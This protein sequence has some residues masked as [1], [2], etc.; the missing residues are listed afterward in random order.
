VMGKLLPS[1]PV[2]KEEEFQRFREWIHNGK[3][4]EGV[5]VRRRKRDGMLIDYSIYASPLRALDGQVIGNVAVLV[6]IT[7]RKQHER[8]REAIIAVST[9]LR[10]ATTRTE[11]LNVIL[12][13]LIHLFDAD[14]AILV[15]PDPQTGG[16]IDGM[17]RGIVGEKMTGLNI[18]P[19]RGVCNWVIKNKKP[20]LSNQADR[21]PLFY[22]PDLLGDSHCIASVP[23]IAQ[24]RAIGAVW[25][26]RQIN[27]VEQDL[28]L[29]NAIAD[30]A[31]NA[32]HRV[33]LHE[34]TEQ[35]LHHLIALHQ[36]D[37]AISNNFDLNITLNVI[38]NKV[39]D[40]LEVDAASILLLGPIT[41]TL[42]YAAG[43][44]F[45][46]HGIEQSHVKLG[47]GCAGR[48]AQDR[49]TVS[50]LNL[51][52]PHGAFVRSLLLAGE[53]FALHYATPLVVKGSV[54]GVL[55]IFNRKAFEPEA[56][57]LNYFETL[58]TQSAIAIE[59][60][61]LFENLQRSNTEL[62]LAYDATIEGWSRALDLRDRE[63]EGHTQR[64]AEMALELAKIMGM[65]DAEKLNLRRGALLHDI[66]KMG[67]PDSILLKP[68]A[69]SEDEMKIMQQHPLYA[70]KM[71]SPIKYLK[72][73]LEIPYCHH[74]KW[75]GSGYPRGLK[76][77]E[78][79]LAAR[80][81]AVVDVYDA[82]TSDRPY[83]KAW[84]REQAHRYLQE[85]A[86]KHFDPQVVRIFLET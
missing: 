77:D 42:D 28:R 69:L 27:L 39:K 48:A 49:R 15:L 31:A 18:P 59:S 7:E 16:F 74:E 71:L 2:D 6:D 62:M 38:L 8:E 65:S 73:A 79:P 5:E 80:V 67:V 21:D 57:W 1:V 46:T 14:G 52:Q 83:R 25:I 53:E 75:D 26:A 36:I 41:H 68:G 63:T 30:I 85:Q 64:V 32:I 4:L 54:K 55:E 13:Q 45:R 37:V 51:G 24:E 50:C 22:R 35:Q 9:A 76:G 33:I 11:I 44:G 17:G 66:G 47:D 70:Y 86:G 23:L 10:R 84:P 72:H 29:L 40:E 20:Y 61:S 78:I 34:Q 43:I 82:L 60:A 56:E 81:F 58:A 19:G 3:I 12:D